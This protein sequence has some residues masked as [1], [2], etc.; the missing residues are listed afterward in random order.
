MCIHPLLDVHHPAFNCPPCQAFADLEV[1]RFVATRTFETLSTERVEKRFEGTT[2]VQSTVR[3]GGLVW[4]RATALLASNN[5]IEDAIAS[6]I[7]ER[8]KTV[9]GPGGDLLFFAIMDGHVRASSRFSPFL[10]AQ[11]HNRPVL[12]SQS[13]S[14]VLPAVVM[15][16]NTLINPP[17]TKQSLIFS[18]AE[19]YIWP[20]VPPLSSTRSDANPVHFSQVL[21]EAFTKL[22]T[23][24]I[25]AP[26]RILAAELAKPDNKDKDPTPDPTKHPLGQAAM[27]PSMSGLSASLRQVA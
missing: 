24:I 21:Q 1:K 16:L 10:A 6:A 18:T 20:T 23:K 12:T 4:H 5:P 13:L 9:K 2:I 3:P 26:A 15:E 17:N 19:S 11:I 14:K 25:G 22:D 7:I 27:M 8:D